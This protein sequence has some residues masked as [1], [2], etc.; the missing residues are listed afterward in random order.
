M[1][2]ER[3]LAIAASVVII[4]AVIGGILLTEGPGH[5][6]TERFDRERAANLNSLSLLIDEEYRVSGALPE[7]L[8]SFEDEYNFDRTSTD[9]RSGEAYEYERSSDTR[10]RLCALFETNG[11]HQLSLYPRAV[12]ETNLQDRHVSPDTL[13]G[14]GRQCFEVSFGVT[15]GKRNGA[16]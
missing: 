6:R 14:T 15:T 7:D 16:P 8:S 13:E 12:F 5:A 1:K 10:Y 11:P 9:P 4:A 3:L 2:P